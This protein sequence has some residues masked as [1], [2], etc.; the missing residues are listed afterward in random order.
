MLHIVVQ[1]NPTPDFK[2]YAYF[3][4]GNVKPYNMTP[5]TLSGLTAWISP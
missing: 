4:D 1:V 3:S 2:I 5:D